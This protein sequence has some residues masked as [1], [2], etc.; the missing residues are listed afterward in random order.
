LQ[1]FFDLN[2]RR[3]KAAKT[4]LKLFS[5]NDL[6]AIIMPSAPHTALPLDC[7]TTATYTGL[8]NYLDYPAIVIP[9]DQVRDIDSTDDLSNAKFGPDDEKLYSLC[10]YYIP[11]V[12]T[13][14]DTCSM[15]SGSEQYKGAPLCIQVVGYRHKDEALIKAAAVLDSIIKESKVAM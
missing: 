15:D 6:D 7:W 13:E 12:K 9:V 4:Y 2:V 5:D 1:G 10:R 3:A 11:N 8:W 14:A